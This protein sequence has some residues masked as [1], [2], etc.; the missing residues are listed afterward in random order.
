MKLYRVWFDEPGWN[1]D[2]HTVVV[3]ESEAEA[4]EKLKVIYH[5]EDYL[6]HDDPDELDQFPYWELEEMSESKESPGVWL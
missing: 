2:G 1:H 4:N 6:Q 5:T 3:A